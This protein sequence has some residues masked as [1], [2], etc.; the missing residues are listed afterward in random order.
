MSS[1]VIRPRITLDDAISIL[2]TLMFSGALGPTEGKAVGYSLMQENENSFV[3]I[4]GLEDKEETE[5]PIHRYRV[6]VSCESGKVEPPKLISLSNPDIANAILCATGHHVAKS[7]RYTDGALSI[8]YRVSVQ[9][10]PIE[11]VLQ[12]RHRENVE[13]MN[14]IMQLVIS[15]VDHRVLPLPTVYPIPNELERHPINGMGIQITRFVPGIMAIGTYPLMKHEQR[16]RFV[17]N[18]A[19]AFDALWQMQLPEAFMIGELRAIQEGNSIKLTALPDRHHS[20][21][22]PFKSVAE[23]LRAHHYKSSKS[24][25]A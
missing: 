1:S 9:E 15:K 19:R 11:Y 21:G 10:D 3:F 24:N 18:L 2:L 13:S 5:Q 7:E 17:K 8:S 25:K 23:Y 22:G 14:A 12:L 20:L 6:V 4:A 16:M